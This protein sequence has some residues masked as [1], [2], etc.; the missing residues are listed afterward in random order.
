MGCGRSKAIASD[1]EVIA[2]KH[3]TMPTV[4][5][6]SQIAVSSKMFVRKHI[7]IMNDTYTIG[8][9]L[10]DGAFGQVTQVTH[11]KSGLVRACKSIEKSNVSREDQIAFKN[12]VEIL[13]N[14]DHPN[15]IKILEFFEEERHFHIVTELCTGGELFDYII[16]QGNLTEK[17]AADIMK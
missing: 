17:V 11:K 5:D 9:V 13:R 10:G 6:T 3:V 8:K 15:V 1:P 4:A 16:S 14:I 2:S 12:E 7:G